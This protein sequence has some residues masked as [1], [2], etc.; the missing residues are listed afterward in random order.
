MEHEM[1]RRSYIH[2]VG[3]MAAI[4]ACTRGTDL[5]RF[6]V[7]VKTSTQDGARVVE[8]RAY[9]RREWEML[10]STSPHQVSSLKRWAVRANKARLRLQG[11]AFNDNVPRGDT[12]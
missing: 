12:T 6:F 3:T 5:F 2:T 8:D 10:A 11:T 9:T 1:S 7:R 4:A